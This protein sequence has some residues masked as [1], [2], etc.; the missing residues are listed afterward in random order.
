VDRR[1]A[2]EG[3]D[4]NLSRQTQMLRSVLGAYRSHCFAT[5]DSSLLSQVRRHD[6]CDLVQVHT[7]LIQTYCSK[8]KEVVSVDRCLI[9]LVTEMAN[10]ISVVVDNGNRTVLALLKRNKGDKRE[11]GL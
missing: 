7:C 4:G 2:A 10:S 8:K 6:L 3:Q 5:H 1:A 11:V 9:I